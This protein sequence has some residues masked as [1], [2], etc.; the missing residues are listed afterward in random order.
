MNPNVAR[1]IALTQV[2]EEQA[3]VMLTA[4]RLNAEQTERLAFALARL[5]CEFECVASTNSDPP[6]VIHQD[7]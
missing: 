2:V 7:V 6:N 5:S 4:S 1:A 3:R